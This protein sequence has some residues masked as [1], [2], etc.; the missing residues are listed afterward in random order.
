MR[1]LGYLQQSYRIH[2][3]QNI[4]YIKLFACN[5]DSNTYAT[6]TLCWRHV[7]I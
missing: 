4:K 6:A 5:A 3:Q 1:Q 7:K 2:G